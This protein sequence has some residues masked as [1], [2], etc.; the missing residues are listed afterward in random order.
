MALEGGSGCIELVLILTS[1]ADTPLRKQGE[2]EEAG[3]KNAVQTFS[4]YCSPVFV[5]F[6]VCAPSYC[7][8]ATCFADNLSRFRME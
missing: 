8:S 2:K 3:L 1:F 6:V 4:D 5:V 7:L